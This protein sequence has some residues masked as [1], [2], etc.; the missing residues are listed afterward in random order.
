LINLSYR[1]RARHVTNN[2][3][4]AWELAAQHPGDDVDLVV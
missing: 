3:D 2:A 4:L 1:G